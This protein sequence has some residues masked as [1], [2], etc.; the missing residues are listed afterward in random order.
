MAVQSSLLVVG[1]EPDTPA[2]EDKLQKVLA[3]NLG[4]VPGLVSVM[5]L[6]PT[7]AAFVLPGLGEGTGGVGIAR[8]LAGTEGGTGVSQEEQGESIIKEALQADFQVVMH[9]ASRIEFDAVLVAVEDLRSDPTGIV[10][11]LAPM[12]G[13]SSLSNGSR[14]LA[15]VTRP[16]QLRSTV[17]YL[18]GPWGPCGDPTA[19]CST[20]VQPFR[21]RKIWCDSSNVSFYF[22]DALC[23]ASAPTTTA[24]CE[25]GADQLPPCGWVINSSWSKCMA[26]APSDVSMDYS[27]A[28]SNCFGVIGAQRRE[29]H[30]LAPHA[31]VEEA[32]CAEPGPASNRSCCAP[33]TKSTGSGLASA[34]G[35]SQ[36]D[37][38][39]TVA[40]KADAGMSSIPIAIGAGLL[41]LLALIFGCCYCGIFCGASKEAGKRSPSPVSPAR[42]VLEADLRLEKSSPT[43]A[44]SPTA[45][46]IQGRESEDRPVVVVATTCKAAT[47]GTNG[48]PP[49]KSTICSV[50][51][52]FEDEHAGELPPG[53]IGA[54]PADRPPSC[55]SVGASLG[56]SATDAGGAGRRSAS[57]G[58]S[59]P[60]SLRITA[61]AAELPFRSLIHDNPGVS[62]GRIASRPSK[63]ASSAGQSSTPPSRLAT[64]LKKQ[65]QQRHGSTVE[66]PSS[67]RSS[68]ERPASRQS[69]MPLDAR[70]L[71][72]PSQKENMLEAVPS[73]EHQSSRSPKS[74]LGADAAPAVGG[75]TSVRP[76]S[77]RETTPVAGHRA[78]AAKP[79]QLAI[80][81]DM[82]A[83]ALECYGQGGALVPADQRH[84]AG[85]GTNILGC[86]ITTP[87][88]PAAPSHSESSDRHLRLPLPPPCLPAPRKF[89]AA[90]TLPL[91]PQPPTGELQRAVWDKEK[92][93]SP[94]QSM[95]LPPAPSLPAAPSPGGSPSGSSG[96]KKKPPPPPPTS[97][98]WRGAASCSGV[99]ALLLRSQSA[100]PLPSRSSAAGVG[101]TRERQSEPSSSE[102][103]QQQPLPVEIHGTPSLPGSRQP[104][105]GRHPN[106][107]R[108]RFTLARHPNLG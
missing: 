76:G 97:S 82:A 11:T 36:G 7:L 58:S 107:D 79:S 56:D 28:Q 89:A 105:V 92:Q 102:Q 8:R 88:V 65:Q 64:A 71:L 103:Q 6:Q 53:S 37:S 74:A 29:V 1:P 98:G 78:A 49:T 59:N 21:S 67:A 91:V 61:N 66:R 25:P 17:A 95:S 39:L 106:V 60:G 81:D 77:Q 86:K 32:R 5:A 47:L 104:N 27:R 50:A 52:A 19:A 24:L 73:S 55:G 23:S 83:I 35:P 72:R 45:I 75:L 85:T 16:N 40:P 34:F 100:Q 18:I 2:L 14:L 13:N 3:Q 90:L 96:I 20:S 99:P 43:S 108:K 44:K 57:L 62:P 101:S 54:S 94:R 84:P 30:C 48:S 68:G 87:A 15:R 31:D 26:L 42:L 46:K 41:T 4:V 93:R 22:D 69:N 63:T 51:T 10:T 38:Y 70:G 80:L 12:L 9:E 33:D